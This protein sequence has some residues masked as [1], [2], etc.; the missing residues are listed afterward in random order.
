MEVQKTNSQ[1]EFF[2]RDAIKNKFN[3]LLGEGSTSFI[4]SLLQIVTSSDLLAKTDPA[5]IYHAACLA[6]T[7]KLPINPALG[8]AYIVP[9]KGKAQFQIG[10]KG[11]IQLAI[12]TCVYETI[13][14]SEIYENELID[15]NPLTGFRFDFS[16][17]LS[18]Q[19]LDDKKIIGY[20]SFIRLK[21]GFEKTLYMSKA[22]VEQHAKMYSQSYKLK[23]GVWNDNFNAMALKTLLK[24]ILGKYGILS[25]D[26]QTAISSDQAV[27]NSEDGTDISYVDNEVVISK[28]PELTRD[29]MLVTALINSA[30]TIDALMQVKE[31]ITTETQMAQ[32]QH[33]F[34]LLKNERAL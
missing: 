29:Q 21:S 2:Q 25:V 17:R 12:R 5:T 27:I 1:K 23:F 13:S 14:V 33:K 16:G 28:Y 30:N 24:L 9:Y 11:L 26:M 6:A 22:Q 32:Y 19:I 10:Y 34:D 4:T 7:L 18:E 8:F 15:S 20:A 31:R 3:E